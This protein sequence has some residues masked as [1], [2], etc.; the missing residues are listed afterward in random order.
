MSYRLP[1]KVGEM[2]DFE[3]RDSRRALD[4]ELKHT[5]TG[6]PARRHLQDQLRAVV[7]EQR[8][9]METRRRANGAEP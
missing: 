5:A 7:R 3:L 9:R 8:E 4:R 2:A 1:H 6:D